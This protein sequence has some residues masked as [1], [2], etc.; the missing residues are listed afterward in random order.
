[1]IKTNQ[2]ATEAA[3]VAFMGDALV[4]FG[5]PTLIV[6]ERKKVR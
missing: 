1:M 5:G 4:E 6:I 2:L 3:S